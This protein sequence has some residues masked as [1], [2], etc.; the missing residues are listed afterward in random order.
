MIIVLVIINITINYPQLCTN[1]K[2]YKKGAGSIHTQFN[3]DDTI[4]TTTT[5]AEDMQH[6]CHG[7]IH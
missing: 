7:D 3:L 2:N 1:S 4:I 6:D 5:S